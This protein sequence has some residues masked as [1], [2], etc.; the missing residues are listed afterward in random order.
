[1]GV[2]I[3]WGGSWKNLKDMSLP[4]TNKNLSK[5]FPDGPHFELDRKVYP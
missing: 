1:L 5:T 3:V 2:E 4:I